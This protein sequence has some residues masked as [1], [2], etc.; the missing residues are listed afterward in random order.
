MKI[1]VVSIIIFLG[2]SGVAYAN[3]IVPCGDD[4][5]CTVCH[6]FELISNIANFIASRFAPIVGALLF[7]YGGIMMIISVGN[8][9]KFQA[10]TKIFWNTIIGLAIIYGAWLIVN[11]LMKTLAGESDISN[12]WYDVECSSGGSDSD[13]RF[14]IS[15]R[16]KLYIDPQTGNVWAGEDSRS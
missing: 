1:L 10:A 7:V 13:S 5:P 2:L 12:K 15:N 8:P 11:S 9:G 16:A 3:G 4:E 6:L 14:P